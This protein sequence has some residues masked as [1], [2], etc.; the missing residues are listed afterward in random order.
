MNF[1]RIVCLPHK[2]KTVIAILVCDETESIKKAY[3]DPEKEGK[4]EV[5]T[6]HD[7]SFEDEELMQLAL[8][9]LVSDLEFEE[10]NP[11]KLKQPEKLF[12]LN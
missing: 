6:L 11:D 2:G 8:D 5:C 1:L 4:S 9:K 7:Y 3:I 10:I 12:N